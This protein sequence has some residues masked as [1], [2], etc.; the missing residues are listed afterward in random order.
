MTQ[1]NYEQFR[2]SLDQTR[3]YTVKTITGASEVKKP[4]EMSES[5]LAD[6]FS[7][8]GNLN[9]GKQLLREAM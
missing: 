9:E 4:S 5:Q 6:L 7:K 1:F 3:F 2:A 8:V